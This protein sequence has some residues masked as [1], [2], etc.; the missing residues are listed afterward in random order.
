MAM[1]RHSGFWQRSKR[2]KQPNRYD[3]TNLTL[4]H[5]RKP[6]SSSGGFR[7]I[8]LALI[9]TGVNRHDVTHLLPLIDAIPPIRGKH[10]RPQSKPAIKLLVAVAASKSGSHLVSGR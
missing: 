1:P 6:P 10:G 5:L 4:S 9:L 3:H 8:P 7:S 2:R